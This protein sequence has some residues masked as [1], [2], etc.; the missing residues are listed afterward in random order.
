M[1][2][3]PQHLLTSLLLL[4]L[5]STAAH[6]QTP[7]LRL[8]AGTNGF[9]LVIGPV[10][11]P[12]L[13]SVQRSGGL[14]TLAS[15]PEALLQ[16]NTP[17]LATI[18]LPVPA[19][20]LDK[21]AFFRTVL[22]A[23]SAVVVAVTNIPTS[24]GTVVVP[25]G[26]PIAGMVLEVPANSYP[27]A[28]TFS[29]SY[30]P[31]GNRRL[32]EFA[33]PITPLINI[34]NGGG[35]AQEM[36][37][38]TLPVSL[39]SNEM[40]VA[41]LLQH[42]TGARF[43]VPVLASSNGTVTI[44]TRH[45]CSAVLEKTT[46]AQLASV[47]PVQTGFDPRADDWE[48]RNQGTYVEPRA[49]CYAYCQSAIWYFLNKKGALGQLFNH[50]DTIPHGFST[51]NVK[52]DN[53]RGLR[54]VGSLQRI[55]IDWRF[56]FVDKLYVAL[57]GRWTTARATFNACHLQLRETKQ[58]Q[59][60]LFPNH[61]VIAYAADANY[62]YIADPNFPGETGQFGWD[63]RY[64]DRLG[65][66]YEDPFFTA[67][68][69][70][71]DLGLIPMLWTKVEAGTVGRDD[72]PTFQVTIQEQEAG[73]WTEIGTA[74]VSPADAANLPITNHT[75]QI[76]V[77]VNPEGGLPT[78]GFNWD[79]MDTNGVILGKSYIPVTFGTNR[80]GVRV[81]AAPELVGDRSGLGWA[82]FSWITVV[83]QPPCD[84]PITSYSVPVLVD[85]PA[86]SFTMGSPDS[87][88]ARG[89]DEGPQTPVTISHA[90]KMGKYEVTQAEYL[91]VMGVNP[92]YFPGDLSRPVEQ[93]SWLEASNYCCR[94]TA[95]EARAGRLPA[96]YA[97]RLPTEA[98]WEYACR[99]GTTTPFHYGNELRSGM[100]NFYGYYEYLA[101]DP[102]HYN[103][104][105][106]Y[107]GRTTSVGS[108]APNAWGLYDMHGNVWEW[109]QDRY[110]PYSGVSVSDPQGPPTGSDRVVRGGDWVI[111]AHYCRSAQ[112]YGYNPPYRYYRI[113]FRVV[114][115]PGQ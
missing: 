111:S 95:C 92:S 94:L 73:Q 112:R 43:Y 78:Y 98:E 35:P 99:A 33:T 79:V 60:I 9:E 27:V 84:C 82:G 25:P 41:S 88:L 16:T 21:Q 38:L 105:G 68:S 102:Y 57:R 12:G 93:V 55:S 51:P 103:A 59:L 67:E 86:G 34:E 31:L 50:F 76:L 101:G 23:E 8:E 47:A 97:Y 87:E 39:A 29:L 18:R 83:R 109:C 80:L 104:G 91:S 81:K 63:G 37:A 115:A 14:A 56:D 6:A 44:L 30:T 66:I 11:M 36:M 96:G 114:L 108:Y 89:T 65:N 28:R 77:Q 2:R 20:P 3:T 90:F 49:A 15:N 71:S 75:A 26:S 106:I 40:V 61:A 46:A 24:G 113:G 58:P 110:G 45:F 7:P 19:R 1:K 100:A 5:G 42:D 85:I 54:F 10:F 69:V 62:I 64:T 74:L 13:L 53:V 4:A 32:S 70:L 48:F 52:D 107:L 17:T 22:Q 72:F